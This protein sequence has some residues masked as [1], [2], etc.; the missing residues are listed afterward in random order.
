VGSGGARR[1]GKKR[2]YEPWR[3]ASDTADVRSGQGR[4]TGRGRGRYDFGAI[5]F[6][7]ILS[8]DKRQNP[9]KGFKGII[10]YLAG[11]PHYH[12]GSGV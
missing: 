9:V 7:S 10:S 6:F 11:T 8:L 2:T 12:R 5:C 3:G 1:G 4:V